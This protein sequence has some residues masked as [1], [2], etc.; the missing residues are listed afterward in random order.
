VSIAGDAGCAQDNRRRV[1]NSG[2]AHTLGQGW[3]T[4]GR[5]PKMTRGIHCC[6][7]LRPASPYCE[8]YVYI[9]TY[10]TVCK[11]YMNYRCHQVTVQRNIFTQIWSGAKCWLDIYHADA[12][13]AVTGRI[14]GIGQKSSFVNWANTWHWT[15]CFTVIFWKVGEYVT[16]DGTFYSFFW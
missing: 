2:T 14:R 4:H 7:N 9:Y 13:L 3:R 5:E 11:L 16:L 10:R 8:L 1:Y 12:G 15:E 6:P